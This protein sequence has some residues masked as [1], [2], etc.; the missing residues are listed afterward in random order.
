MIAT[1]MPGKLSNLALFN[2]K[3]LFSF[4]TLLDLCRNSEIVRSC[5]LFAVCET[6]RHLPI[7]LCIDQYSSQ[8]TSQ[9]KGF[10][11][12]SKASEKSNIAALINEVYAAVLD[13]SK[14]FGRML[15]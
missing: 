10:G 11:A 9:S 1:I 4:R 12:L 6:K 5:P 3:R 8:S 2:I 14:A 7:E 13:F 15:L